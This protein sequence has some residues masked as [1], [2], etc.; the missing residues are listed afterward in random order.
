M[1]FQT[2][3]KMETLPVQE[4]SNLKMNTSRHLVSKVRRIVYIKEKMHHTDVNPGD[5][6]DWITKWSGWVTKFRCRILLRQHL[7]KFYV[8]LDF[9]D[10]LKIRSMLI[11]NTTLL[12]MNLWN[13]QLTQNKGQLISES[14]FWNFKF[15]K[16]PPK[17]LTNFCQRIQKVV[18]L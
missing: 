6:D 14:P 9:F 4:W 11:S 10:L 18:K 16:N 17:N 7:I 8:R 2:N 3:R 15:S 1:T 12:G 13:R 5:L